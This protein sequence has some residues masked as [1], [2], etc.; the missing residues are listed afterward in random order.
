MLLLHLTQHLPGA[1]AGAVV[2]AEQFDLE[3][4]RKDAL[5]NGPQCR[6]LVVNRHHNG[7][8]H[9]PGFTL[10]GKIKASPESRESITAEAEKRAAISQFEFLASC[11]RTD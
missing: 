5:D 4:D 11:C 6:S 10:D 7:Q 1:V 9:A 8:F 3:A 2:H